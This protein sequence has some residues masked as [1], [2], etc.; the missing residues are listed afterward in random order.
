MV[1]REGNRVYFTIHRADCEQLYLA[2]DFNDWSTS[3]CPM[4]RA[5]DG[6]WFCELNLTPGTYRFR[7]FCHRHGWLT[8][9]A[10]FG[11]KRNALGSWD[12]VVEVPRRV[13]P[14]VRRANRAMRAAG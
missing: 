4:H 14:V 3:Q 7:Y 11:V 9:W 6:R 2:G 5:A 12:S 1:E 10:A 8:D 13:S